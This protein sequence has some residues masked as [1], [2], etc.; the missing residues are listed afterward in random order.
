MEYNKSQLKV[1]NSKEPRMIVIAPA[2]SGKTSS[3]VGAVE[4]YR[5]DFPEHKIVVVTFTKK[6]TAELIDRIKIANI[7]IS[8]IH[9]WAYSQLRI[10]G[11]KYNFKIQLLEE[12]I[13]KDILKQLC[14]RRK[15]YYL[16]QFQLF[17]YVM[18]N[19]N[20]DVDDS[21]KKV[22]EIIR[23]DYI[24]Y[25]RS[26]MLYDFTDLPEY[27]YDKLEEY[28]ENIKSIDALFVDEIQDADE[29]QLKLF[30]RIINC[31]KKVYIGD[32][33]QSIYMFR[34]ANQ[35][36]LASLED[37]VSFNLIVNYR[38][39]QEI[40]DFA[41]SF[42]NY[43]INKGVNCGKNAV[44]LTDKFKIEPSN[45]ICKRGNGANIYS[46]SDIGDCL[47]IL[48]GGSSTMK[49][50][51][52]ILKG[53]LNDKNTQ[54]LCRS[55]RQVKKLQS[56]GVEKVS[57]VHQAKGL[58]YDNVIIVDFPVKE[59]E[60]LNI[61]YVAMTRAKNMLCICNYETL[62]SVIINNQISFSV[63]KLF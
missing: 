4:K 17:S 20:I 43:A 46:I 27:L 21:I 12:E 26:Q 30:D 54:I 1:I 7:D 56:L 37:F 18:G 32:P 48:E 62:L 55:N 51:N 23:Y 6:A 29:I 15:Q 24:K 3:I 59:L 9:S 52:L 39:Y 45:I 60:S 57:T 61:A 58:E 14:K 22:F 8:T 41:V 63:S 5:E 2:G 44:M 28:A 13:I 16:N 53:L 42:R 31:N 40:I 36:L 35:E 34:G 47:E 19:Y 38:S 49:D 10:L 33:K 11:S 25:K 50:E